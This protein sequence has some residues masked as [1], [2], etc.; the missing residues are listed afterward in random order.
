[1]TETEILLFLSG[2]ALTS[3]YTQIGNSDSFGVLFSK[4]CNQYSRLTKANQTYP[5]VNISAED[6]TQGK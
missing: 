5:K 4:P 6:K 1:M 3:I 2:N